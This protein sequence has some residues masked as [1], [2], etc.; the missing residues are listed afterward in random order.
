MFNYSVT[1]CGNT[2]SGGGTGW[3]GSHIGKLTPHCTGTQGS[4]SFS[5][6]N[7]NGGSA[8]FKI[9]QQ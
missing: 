9:E 5:T 2:A 8:T 3:L 4:F 1:T 7:S 6:A